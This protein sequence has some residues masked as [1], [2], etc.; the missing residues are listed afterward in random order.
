MLR[1]MCKSKIHRAII[2][3]ANIHYTGSITIDRRLMEEADIYPFERVQVA[4]LHNGTRLET[5]VI[6]GPEDSGVICMNGA[7]ARCAEVGDPIL[8]ISYA[9]M[10]EKEAQAVTPKVV[11]VDQKNRIT[12][13]EICRASNVIPAEAGINDI[14]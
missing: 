1:T 7:A 9:T 14:P 6:E 10:E 13:V 12:K 5:Y 3:E 4:N 11:H 8:I 2:T